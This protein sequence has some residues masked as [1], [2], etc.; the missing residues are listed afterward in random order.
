V[1]RRQKIDK[2]R[3]EITVGKRENSSLPQ[4]SVY[5]STKGDHYRSADRLMHKG[6]QSCRNSRSIQAL[7]R[8]RRRWRRSSSVD[9]I[10]VDLASLGLGDPAASNYRADEGAR[11]RRGQNPRVV[12]VL[13]SWSGDVAGH[14]PLRLIGGGRFPPPITLLLVSLAL[15]RVDNSDLASSHA[16]TTNR[17]TG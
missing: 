16:C 9:V 10:E 6:D 3:H 5:R 15:C 4:T 8:G 2:C 11:D 14:R 17:S 12:T 13:E 7:R 1:L